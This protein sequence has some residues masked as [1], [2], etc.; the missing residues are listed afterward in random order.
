MKLWSLAEGR[1]PWTG[2]GCLGRAD[3]DLSEHD[4]A[5]THLDADICGNMLLTGTEEGVLTLWDVRQDSLVWQV[6]TSLASVVIYLVPGMR[7]LVPTVDF[8]G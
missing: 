6:W 3:R 5:V 8:L 7:P 2:V 4:S 1:Q